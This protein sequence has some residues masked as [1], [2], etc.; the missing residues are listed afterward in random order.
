MRKSCVFSLLTLTIMLGL[1][2]LLA[3]TSESV[4]HLSGPARTPAEEPRSSVTPSFEPETGPMYQRDG[5]M[6]TY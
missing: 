3:F 1:V 2:G 6:L 5:L 4:H